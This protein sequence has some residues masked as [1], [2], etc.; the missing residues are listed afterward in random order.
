MFNFNYITK[1]DIKKQNSNLSEIPDHP[2]KI[3]I[4]GGSWSGTTNA[5]L[6]LINHEPDI[7]RKSFIC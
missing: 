2:Y 3:L 1:E 5:L 6:N 7:D 4:V